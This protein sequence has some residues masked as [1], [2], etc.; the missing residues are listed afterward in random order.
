MVH[1]YSE[2]IAP[3]SDSRK[4]VHEDSCFVHLTVGDEQDEE[5]WFRDESNLH[6]CGNW[7][8]YKNDWVE[9]RFRGTTMC[10]GAP[11]CFKQAGG[12]GTTGRAPSRQPSG[13]GGAAGAEPK[14]TDRKQGDLRPP[15]LCG[16]QRAESSRQR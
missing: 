14:R 9:G 8:M 15:L 10:K 3:W 7:R 4:F 13:T 11:V 12:A 6:Q 1:L 5:G 2:T 16:G